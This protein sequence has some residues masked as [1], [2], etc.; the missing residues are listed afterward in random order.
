VLTSAATVLEPSCWLSPTEL[1]QTPAD[2]HRVAT[3]IV[4]SSLTQP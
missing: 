3:A 4:R 1:A 2:P